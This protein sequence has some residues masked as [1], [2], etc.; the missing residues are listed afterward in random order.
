MFLEHCSGVV[1]NLTL[2]CYT[3]EKKANSHECA[4]MIT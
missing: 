2:G 1:T 3:I 4:Q